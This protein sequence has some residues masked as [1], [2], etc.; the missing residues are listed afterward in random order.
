MKKERQSFFDVYGEIT[1][2]REEW[3]YFS[4]HNPNYGIQDIFEENHAIDFIKSV[5]KNGAKDKALQI[6]YDSRFPMQRSRSNHT[7]SAY[8]LGL[9]IRN[10]M[11]I[12]MKELPKVNKAPTKNFLYFWSLT[13]LYHD[14]TVALED[15]S[16]KYL[17][18][19]GTIEDFFQYFHIEYS[20]LEDNADGSLIKNYYLYRIE[21][22]KKVDHGL[23]SAIL[24]FDALMKQYNEAR[25]VTMAK[26]GET[27]FY[28]DLKYSAGFEEH[29][30]LVANT[31]A[32]HN[33]WR[34]DKKLIDVYKK[35]NLQELIPS[36]NNTHIVFLEGQSKND[37]EKLL[38][39]L[40]LVDTIEPIKCLGRVNNVERIKNPY[41][42]LEKLKIEFN[43]KKGEIRIEGP[44]TIIKDYGQNIAGAK[45]WLGVTVEEI[46]AQQVVRIIKSKMRKNS[47]T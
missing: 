12:D 41:I 18:K 11:H 32:K 6:I 13:C 28:N 39:L 27:F 2:D 15:D 22:N 38:F 35:Y 40:G 37:K 23:A 34:A 20:L 5:F 26:K 29:I 31:I 1:G 10:R 43:Y 30:R 4:T 46:G 9:V 47:S 36:K 42:A 33:M 25:S 3:C 8:L 17:D 14:F 7:L 21:K 44:R 45:Q 16:A 19:L 24:L